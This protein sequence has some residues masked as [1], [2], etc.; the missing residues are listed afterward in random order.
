[1][2]L[3]YLMCFLRVAEATDMMMGTY[4]PGRY[5][6]LIRDCA[7]AEAEDAAARQWRKDQKQRMQ[8]KAHPL[9][10]A[11]TRGGSACKAKAVPGKR[12]CRLH[13][14]LSTGPKTQTGREAI[15]ESNRR[16]AKSKES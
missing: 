16:R 6:K 2:S 3:D 5:L 4:R 12:R 10:G 9:C 8:K 13:G 1:M 15:A 7:E 11:V 14:G